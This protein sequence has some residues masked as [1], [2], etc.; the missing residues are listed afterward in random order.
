VLAGATAT[1]DTT[2][3]DC[4]GVV[5]AVPNADR[6]LCPLPYAEEKCDAPT[7]PTNDN[8]NV[9]TAVEFVIDADYNAVI[10]ATPAYSHRVKHFQDQLQTY[11]TN[12][13]P[14]GVNSS[15][16]DVKAV[17]GSIVVS[18][19]V[20]DS[21][22]LNDT[23]RGELVDALTG[24]LASG[25][26][27]FEFEGTTYQ[28]DNNTITTESV[29]PLATGSPTLKP[30]ASPVVST[31]TPIVTTTQVAPTTAPSTA[32]TALATASASNGLGSGA[33]AGIVVG[34]IIVLILILI[35]VALVRQ[36]SDRNMFKQGM[37]SSSVDNDDYL[38]VNT[39][40]EGGI[41][42]DMTDENNKLQ[43]EVDAMGTRIAR[44]NAVI[45][46]QHKSQQLAQ[47][48][49]EVAIAAKLKK[50]NDSLQAEIQAMKDDLKKKRQNSK[51][52]KAAA[53]QAQL[54]AEKLALE[55]EIVRSDQV[56]QIALEALSEY[57]T[58]QA[59]LEEEEQQARQQEIDRI[60]EEKDRL[61]GEMS[62]L[63]ER[64]SGL[65]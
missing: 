42:G 44:K 46:E 59:D 30:T 35:V 48:T 25:A 17:Q 45:S 62:R 26:F 41:D 60:Q 22:V 12:E 20:F 38:T 19:S 52:Q 49:L 47:R 43:R 16:G 64:L 34:C 7:P 13:A 24:W 15:I 58:L 29:D 3:L 39:E 2:C 8:V 21:V 33:V 31:T 56:A 18:F 14:L 54:K 61:A 51:F 63:T 57:D 11:L 32:P 36:Q 37:V 23:S 5:L 28:L 9:F 4:E 55:E 27:D 1:S 50:E 6:N 10:T 40:S 65:G 53:L